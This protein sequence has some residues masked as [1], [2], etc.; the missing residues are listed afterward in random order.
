MTPHRLRRPA[1][2]A[3]ALLAS[4]AL[5]A[6]AE[7]I[8]ATYTV[9]AAGMT[10]MEINATLDVS[11]SGY[12]VEFRSRMRGLLSAFASGQTTTRVEG[13]WDGA[14]ARPRRYVSEGVWRGEPRRTVLEWQGRQPV[15][16]AM[17]PAN[18]DEREPVPDALQRNTIDSLSAIAQ[19][20]RQVR[21]EG[22]CNGAARIYDG[23]RL[24]ELAARTQGRDQ[25]PPARGEWSGIAMKCAFEGRFLAGHRK[26][27]D[28][29]AARRPQAG[30]AWLAEVVPGRPPI[31]VRIDHDS[32]WLGTLTARLASFG[33]SAQVQAPGRELT[34][35]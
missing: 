33:P 13:V 5:P 8:S 12:V 7:T 16:R 26:G 19:L 24:S 22:H 30:T 10:V 23:R 21:R 2:L 18:Q 17:V 1:L 4:A 6:R 11:E 15:V 35:G 34:P 27:E 9:H 29:E 20:V 32:R 3:A 25:F 14:T 31:P 28:V